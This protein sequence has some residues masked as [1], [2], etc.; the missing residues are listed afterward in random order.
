MDG[1]M[2]GWIDGW[3]DR[4]MN[5]EGRANIVKQFNLT[6]SPLV[7]KCPTWGHH[8]TVL[9]VH[10]CNSP[11]LFL[12]IRFVKLGLKAPYL[13]LEFLWR[14]LQATVTGVGMVCLQEVPG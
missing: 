7:W 10:I 8:I 6:I 13:S 14:I 5:K 11:P 4:W 12:F 9:C 1:W 3:I 2:D